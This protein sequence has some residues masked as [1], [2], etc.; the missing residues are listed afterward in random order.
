L[1]G[2]LVFTTEGEGGARGPANGIFDKFLIKTA[3]V[4]RPGL[5]EVTTTNQ[6]LISFILTREFFPRRKPQ[7]Y[8]D[9]PDP[10]QIAALP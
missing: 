2:F 3:K 7:S 5:Y 8:P 6:W 4:L 1:A 10:F 9:F